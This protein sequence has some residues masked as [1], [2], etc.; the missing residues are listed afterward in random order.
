MLNYVTIE[1]GE[2]MKK[3][4]TLVELLAIITIIGIVAL[5]VFPVVINSIQNAKQNLYEIQVKDIQAAAEKWSTDHIEYLDATHLNTVGVP[6][7]SLILSEYLQNSNILD[8]RDKSQMDG[9]VTVAYNDTTSQYQHRYVESSCE[10]AIVHGMIYSYQGGT[11]HKTE[12]DMI[13]LASDTIINQYVT[14]NLLKVDGE[15]T[16]GFYDE[17][18]RYIFRGIDVNNY[19]KLSGGNEVYRILSIDKSTG[20]I[21]LMGTTAILNVWDNNSGTMFENASVA[22]VQL[23]NYYNSSSNGILANS[24]KIVSDYEWNVGT[25]TSDSSYMVLKSLEATRKV[26]GKIGLPSMS[27][28]AGASTNK[29][30]HT[31]ILSNSCKEQ[32]YLYELWQGK[33]NWLINTDE[34]AIW[35]IDA[36][37]HYNRADAATIHYIYPVIEIKNMYIQSGIG[38]SIRPYIFG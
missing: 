31:S 14:A 11:W 4:F 32:N 34:T 2:D 8:P 16:D 27:D 33:N 17:G 26:Y 9:C 30:C 35:Y 24:T 36:N 12:K 18:E 20:Y 37:G 13:Q 22:T 38:T 3:G 25:I 23:E 10:E 28:Y 29:K 1:L 19:V 7:T 6:L 21:R 15:T 5:I